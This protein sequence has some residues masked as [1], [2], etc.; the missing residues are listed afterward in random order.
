[1]RLKGGETTLHG[2]EGKSH[3]ATEQTLPADNLSQSQLM[4]H[5]HSTT[6]FSAWK[7]NVSSRS[8]HSLTHCH[9][10][11]VIRS[12]HMH[13]TLQKCVHSSFT[14]IQN[15]LHP[16]LSCCCS[17]KIHFRPMCANIQHVLPR[18]SYMQ[19][20]FC[21]KIWVVVGHAIG[22]LEWEVHDL[23]RVDHW[24]V[25][26][27]EGHRAPRERTLLWVHVFT[28]AEPYP[29][30]SMDWW[31]RRKGRRKIQREIETT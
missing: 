13:L 30:P 12:A 27:C 17:V 1:M 21:G 7:N 4:S 14:A 3:R 18:Y 25:L 2:R 15:T 16:G 19:G 9:S 28:M 26:R 5:L 8:L 20:T 24:L 10:R 6:W 31:K 23:I 29:L 22:P 11:L